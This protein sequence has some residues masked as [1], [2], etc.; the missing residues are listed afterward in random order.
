MTAGKNQMNINIDRI[1][2][3]DSVQ[4]LFKDEVIFGTD[5]TDV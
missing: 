1:N 2:G 5:G 4:H 3:H